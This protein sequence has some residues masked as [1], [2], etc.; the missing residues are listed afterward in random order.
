LEIK[1]AKKGSQSPKME[2]GAQNQYGRMIHLS[3]GNYICS[4]KNYTFWGQKGENRLP[5]PINGIWGPK[6][7]WSCD[8]SIVREFYTEQENYTF[9]GQKGKNKP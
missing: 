5:E 8:T 3:T 1:K 7:V 9:S 6:P 2:F 4:K